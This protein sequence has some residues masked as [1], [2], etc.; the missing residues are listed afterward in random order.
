MAFLLEL[1]LL[2]EEDLRGLTLVPLTNVVELRS[3]TRREVA[4][5][6][7]CRRLWTDGPL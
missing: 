7:A 4:Q 2:A 5:T 3:R 1:G 6:R